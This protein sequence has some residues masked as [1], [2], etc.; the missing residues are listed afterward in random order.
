MKTLLLGLLAATAIAPGVAFAQEGGRE[1]AEQHEQ[2]GTRPID[3]PA[4]QFQ[5]AQ[6]APPFERQ[7]GDRAQGAS[8]QAPQRQPRFEQRDFPRPQFQQPQFQQPARQQQVQP[9][10]A[11]P[12]FQRDRPNFQPRGDFGQNGRQTGRD[13]GEV[14]R[15]AGRDFRQDRRQDGRNF[16]RDGRT[17]NRFLNNNR[18]GNSYYGYDNRRDYGNQGQWNRAWRRNNQYNW[19]NYR[20]YNQGIFNLPRYYSPYGYNYGY[21]R[22]SIGSTLDAVLF[23]RNYWIEDPYY[24]RLPVAYGPYKWVRYYGDA[25]LVDLRTCEIVDVVY[26]IFY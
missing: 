9:P 22:F 11:A 2:I 8:V 21:Q 14:Q 25:V 15:Q 26:D 4:P 24:Y 13:F 7:R 18:F 20:S 5:R 19:Q 12:Q 17:D 3:G 16:R 1:I 23:N 10:Q 6:A